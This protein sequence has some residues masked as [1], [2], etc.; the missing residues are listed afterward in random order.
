[1][2]LR[3]N[4]ENFFCCR[5]GLDV[6][7]PPANGLSETNAEP[8][9][10]IGQDDS[11]D[12][13]IWLTCLLSSG[14]IPSHILHKNPFSLDLD[15]LQKNIQR[16]L[17]DDEKK[18]Q[19]GISIDMY[20][21]VH[22]MLLD[23]TV[24]VTDPRQ[25]YSSLNSR[26]LK[27]SNRWNKNLG[28]SNGLPKADIYFALPPIDAPGLESVSTGFSP[29]GGSPVYRNAESLYSGFTDSQITSGSNKVLCSSLPNLPT[30]RRE[31]SYSKAWSQK[32]DPFD[33]FF[34]TAKEESL[35]Y[36]HR[37]VKLEKHKK[38]LQQVMVEQ[39][40]RH[41]RKRIPK[42]LPKTSKLKVPSHL[43]NEKYQ[44][45]RLP[46]KPCDKEKEEKFRQGYAL[47]QKSTFRL[48]FGSVP[49]K[50]VA[51]IT[52]KKEVHIHMWQREYPQG[53]LVPVSNRSAK[54]LKVH[55][56]DSASPSNNS[57]FWLEARPIQPDFRYD[58]DPSVSPDMAKDG[59]T[60]QKTPQGTIVYDSQNINT[61]VNPKKQT[62]QASVVNLCLQNK[63]KQTKRESAVAFTTGQPKIGSR[64]NNNIATASMDGRNANGSDFK[65]H[66]MERAQGRKV[67]SKYT[68][69]IMFDENPN[70]DPVSLAHN[71]DI[72]SEAVSNSGNTQ[73]KHKSDMNNKHPLKGELS[74][75]EVGRVVLPPIPVSRR[76]STL[77]EKLLIKNY[78]KQQTE[79][80]SVDTGGKH[81]V[82]PTPATSIRTQS[83][84]MEPTAVS[85]REIMDGIKETPREAG[86]NMGNSPEDNRTKNLD[87]TKIKNSDDT[88]TK[89]SDNTR[90][91]N[92]DDTRMENKDDTR[93]E[94]LD[95]KK[96]KNLDESRIEIPD[97]R[98]MEIPDVKRMENLDD[99]RMENPGDTRKTDEERNLNET[100]TIRDEGKEDVVYKV[101]NNQDKV[102]S[103][104]SKTLDDQ[105]DH[106][107]QQENEKAE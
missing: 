64:P 33:E 52:P 37:Q 51:D 55:E 47:N 69:L 76:Q 102:M 96:I 58:T 54:D 48:A 40:E 93:M 98:R 18:T 60:T 25:W 41:Y 106:P 70:D 71:N 13:I 23:P 36:A 97:D 87:D 56:S 32:C 92:P 29:S 72:K 63:E 21:D 31:T 82:Y 11:L 8:E 88:R 9:K 85:T 24:D 20:Q 89:N 84:L 12:D 107:F 86:E 74:T 45:L 34:R 83:N 5:D 101:R 75:V 62:A 65:N 90:T 35:D 22:Q 30:C 19:T 91:K 1:M 61:Q 43:K 94:N 10:K 39:K 103:I 73:N 66:F 46:Q 4:D 42:M 104:E 2:P 53:Y 7:P 68:N 78:D 38:H 77:Y 16:K 67:L 3:E 57:T 28:Y 15:L 27:T 100:K 95:N 49:N 59:K 105:H 80:D 6:N 14:Y 99:R 17:M 81:K 26:E 79:L 50:K 44:R